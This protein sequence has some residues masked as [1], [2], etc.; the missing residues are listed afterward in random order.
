MF[1]SMNTVKV[2]SLYSKIFQFLQLI[3]GVSTVHLDSPSA[4]LLVHR[5]STSYALTNIGQELTTFNN[6]HARA[7]QPRWLTS[8]EIL[9]GAKALT[10]VI[11]DT[12]PKGR[13]LAQQSP[14]SAFSST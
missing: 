4:E 9:V 11:T 3:P 2:S 10:I 13:D 12:S 7:Q 8:D 14:L 1:T 6:G 5:I